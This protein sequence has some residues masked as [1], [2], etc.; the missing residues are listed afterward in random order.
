MRDNAIEVINYRGHDI[1]VF[2]DDD[3]ESPDTWGNEDVFIVHEH[4][5]FNVERRGF[6]PQDIFEYLQ[7]GKKLYAGYWVFPLY[8]YIHSGVSLSLGK[9]TYPFT[10]QWDT[11]F[12]GFVL[13]KRTKGWS[14]TEE[15]ACVIAGLEVDEWNMYLSGDVYGYN[16]EHGSCWGFYGEEGMKDMIEDAKAEIDYAIKEELKQHLIQLKQWIKAKVPLQYRHSF[17][18]S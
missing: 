17:K 11:S 5:Q 2:Q 7:S 4:R 15:K 13:V 3:V 10:C 8:A 6:D 1:E 14:W 9:N 12:A 16:S 18:E